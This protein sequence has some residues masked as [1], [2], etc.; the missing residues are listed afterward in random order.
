MMIKKIGFSIMSLFLIWQI[1]K[2]LVNLSD[3][4]YLGYFATILLAWI[5][6]LSVTGIFAFPGFVF[7]TEKM[8]SK[9]YYEI[10]NPRKLKSTFKFLKLEY[11]RTILLKTIWRSRKMQK[12]YFDGTKAGLD[13]LATSSMKSEFG[14][15]VPFVLQIGIAIYALTLG[16]FFLSFWITFF[17]VLANL[18][19]AI[20]QRHHRMRIAILKKRLLSK[21]KAV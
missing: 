2:L 12:S 7:P 14:H 5:I 11:F 17:N 13:N 1:S 10:H 19:P 6:S 20:L 21:A 15:D 18:F 9:R 16:M 4:N 8:L 3:F